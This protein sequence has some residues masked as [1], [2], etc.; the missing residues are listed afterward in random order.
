MR[1]PTRRDE[2]R[3]EAGVAVTGL[4]AM[5]GATLWS[6]EPWLQTAV[7]GTRPYVATGFDVVG[8]AGWLL[9]AAGLVGFRSAF[10]PRYG[11][12]GRV[13]VWTTGLGMVL[14]T[15]VYTRSV[16][17]FVD[18]GLRPVPATGEDPAGLVVTLGIVL[19]LTLTVLGTGMLGVVLRRLDGRSSITAVLLVAAPVVPAV[20]IGLRFLSL[21]PLP[22]GMQLVGTNLALVPFGVAWL[23]L[24]WLVWTD[25]RDP[26]SR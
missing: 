22:L 1:L 9:M 16:V 18:A 8:W 7:F 23:T 5:A 12:L 17:A 21:L 10:R 19:G 26:T 3:S 6:V 2:P 11:R 24:G 13:G 14:V 25:S 20:A 15:L 4:A